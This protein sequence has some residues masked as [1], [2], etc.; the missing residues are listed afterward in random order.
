MLKRVLTSAKKF[1]FSET[2]IKILIDRFLRKNQKGYVVETPEGMFKRAS[3]MIADIDR[4]FGATEEEIENFTKEVYDNYTARNF[5]ATRPL[6][7]GGRPYPYQQLSSCYVFPIEDSM[8]GI[9]QTLHRLAFLQKWGSPAGV[10]YSVLRPRGDLIRSTG[11]KNSGPVSFMKIF[12]AVTEAISEGA[13]R[14]GANMGV[15]R[16]DH[17]DIEE[18]ITSKQTPG[19]LENFNISVSITDDFM[20]KAKTNRY[21]WLIN[22][23]T[24]EKVK[25]VKA[26]KILELIV[27]SMWKS[28]EP[29]IIFIDEINRKNPTPHIG[30]ITAVN[31]CGE[32]P[33]LPYEACNLCNLNLANFLTNP[34][35]GKPSIDW[36]SLEQTI[37]TVVHFLDNSIEANH[38]FFKEIEEIVK[39]GNRKIG[40][41]LMGWA[42]VLYKMGLPYDSATAIKLGEKTMKFITETGH[43]ESQKL[44]RVRGAFPNFAGSIWDKPNADPVRNAAVTTVAPTGNAALLAGCSHA[45]E[46]HYALAFTRVGLGRGK[47][48]GDWDQFAYVNEDFKKELSNQGFLTK[49]MKQEILES[50]SIQHIRGIP[51]EIKSVFKTALDLNPSA[52][53]KMQAAFQKYCDS[54]I[55]KTINMPKEGTKRD[56]EKA[57]WMAWRLKCKGITIYRDQSR[58]KQVLTR[59][60]RK[61]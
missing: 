36:K 41:G 44:A 27:D 1:G 47:S 58:N 15:L 48:F 10:D 57:I 60:I 26:R 5:M 53:I 25:K 16:V 14:R 32:Q 38:Y 35:R 61:K 28:A 40:V 54:A 13:T 49:K 43:K 8:D 37:E 56:V 34:K 31:L 3:K 17:P 21:Y 52:H 30:E 23:R 50:G 2:A 22:P 6:E 55:S 19:V 45:I 51:G 18:F 7:N 4:E 39:Q 59:G 46:P 33:L 29:G 12:D 11:G 9:F 20:E 42:D 24:N